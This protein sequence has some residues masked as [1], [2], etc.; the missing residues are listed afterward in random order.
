MGLRFVAD[1]EGIEDQDERAIRVRDAYERV[2]HL[3]GALGTL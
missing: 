3:L 1:L 2:S